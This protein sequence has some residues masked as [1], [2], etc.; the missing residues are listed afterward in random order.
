MA[1]TTADRDALKQ[2]I[3]KGESRVSFGDRS[4]EYRSMAEMQ[5]AL[6]M[7]ETEL[8]SQ[9]DTPHPRRW[10]LYGEKGL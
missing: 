2:A 5:T 9:S 6:A 7:I 8:S 10:L 4:V 1:W 3:A